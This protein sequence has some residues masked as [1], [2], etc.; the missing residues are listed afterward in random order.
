MDPSEL[1]LRDIHLPDPVAWWPPAPG[2]WLLATVLLVMLGMALRRWRRRRSVAFQFQQELT[3]LR[4][5]YARDG[6]ASRLFQRGSVLLRRA[7]LSAFPREQ[8]AGLSGSSWSQFVGSLLE[9][10]A[11]AGEYARML[12][13]APYRPLADA[14]TDAYLDLLARVASRL[15]VKPESG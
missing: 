4:S 1:P 7:C 5:E 10:E 6:D 9:P 15:N 11:R 2:W 12:C 8:V 13:E 14:D 3:R